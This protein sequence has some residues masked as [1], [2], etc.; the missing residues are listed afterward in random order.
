[1]VLA[2]DNSSDFQM[3]VFRSDIVKTS[4]ADLD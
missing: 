1:M 3:V 2:D 4:V